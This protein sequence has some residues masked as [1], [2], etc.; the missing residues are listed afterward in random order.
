MASYASYKKI[1]GASLSAGSLTADKINIDVRKTFGVQ[2]F[3]GSPNS[4]SAG[5]CCL[6]TVPSGVTSIHFELWGSGG[7]GSGACSTSRCQHYK[8]AGGGGYNSKTIQVCPTWTYT[9]CAA[10][11]G[12]CCRFECTGCIGCSSYV[13]G[14]N[15]TNFCAIGGSPGCATGDWSTPCMSSWDCCIQSGAN[16]GDFGYVN[17]S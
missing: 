13:T 16:G 3:Y 6:W 2:W 4:A 11:N 14:C 5:C 12:P 10:G 7:S 8:G 15:L 9:I 1:D 17:H